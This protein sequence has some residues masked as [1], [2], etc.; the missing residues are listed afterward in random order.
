M[1]SVN[2]L[3]VTVLPGESLQ[4][5][6]D[7][8]NQPILHKRSIVLCGHFSKVPMM[9]IEYKFDCISLFKNK[10]AGTPVFDTYCESTFLRGHQ[11]SW[12]G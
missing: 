11:F 1:F 5:R 6:T 2:Y 7:N 10:C 9:T 12:F 4:I 8:K 3:R